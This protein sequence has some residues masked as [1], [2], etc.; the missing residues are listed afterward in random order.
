[1]ATLQK[2]DITMEAMIH[3]WMIYLHIYICIHNYIY[4]HTYV[5]LHLPTFTHIYLYDL[6]LPTFTYMYPLNMS[7]LHTYIN[8]QMLSAR[9][10]EVSLRPWAEHPGVIFN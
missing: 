1:M 2:T 5:Y 3:L 9:T 6:Y 7:I 4:T 10:A 8:Y